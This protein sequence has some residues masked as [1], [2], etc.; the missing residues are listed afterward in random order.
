MRTFLNLFGHS[1]FGMLASHMDKV[2]DCVHM[3]LQLFATLEQQ[4]FAQLE[5]IAEQISESEHQADL[6]KNTLR[7]HLS[8]SLYLAIDRGALLEMLAIQDS[9]ADHAEDIAVLITLKPMALLPAFKTEFHQF[10]QKNI[11]TF[12]GVRKIM[13]ELHELLESSFGGIEAERVCAMVDDVAHKEH[14]TDIIQRE[15][16]KKLYQAEGEMSY[17]TFHLWQKIF[18]ATASISNLS[19][20]LAHRVRMTLDLK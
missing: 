18:E 16:L 1:P 8:K 6:I 15:L 11:D 14:E 4:Q 5:Q 3:L 2:T 19:E 13:Q 10:L 9:I 7:N 17:A 12:N 20:K